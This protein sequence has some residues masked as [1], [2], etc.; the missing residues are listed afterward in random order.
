MSIQFDDEDEL[1]PESASGEVDDDD[2]LPP[3]TELETD[4][5]VDMAPVRVP[6]PGTS[7]ESVSK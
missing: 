6:P 2:E 3:R 7:Y 1:E 5:I 4:D